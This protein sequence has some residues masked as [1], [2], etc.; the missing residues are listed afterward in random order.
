MPQ[1]QKRRLSSPRAGHCHRRQ[2]CRT[3][4]VLK[5]ET[6]LGS[7][8]WTVS[9]WIYFCLA[10]MESGQEGWIMRSCGRGTPNFSAL[11][12]H[13]IISRSVKLLPGD[14]LMETLRLDA[15]DKL[16][17]FGIILWGWGI[18]NSCFGVC[19][20]SRICVSRA[21]FSLGSIILYKNKIFN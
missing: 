8:N 3:P 20:N 10:H 21:T 9:V 11:Q 4:P 6:G 2:K 18:V 14:S 7:F 15:R 17:N 16:F 5:F 13:Y 1:L 19:P 12:I